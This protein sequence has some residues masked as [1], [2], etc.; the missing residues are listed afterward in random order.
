M[1]RVQRTR[2]SRRGKKLPRHPTASR[3]A[4]KEAIDQSLT[5]RKLNLQRIHYLEDLLEAR[6]QSLAE[7]ANDTP[8]RRALNELRRTEMQIRTY[9]DEERL[10][11][12]LALHYI[13][14]LHRVKKELLFS[15]RFL[16]IE[17][18]EVYLT[19]R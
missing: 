7:V 2:H 10:S 14:D 12:L 5:D 1:T 8:R 9:W 13:L 16:E 15:A 18:E 6:K 17:L 4:L 19:Q 3:E 11:H